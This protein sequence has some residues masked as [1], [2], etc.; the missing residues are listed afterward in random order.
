[1]SPSAHAPS[2][3]RVHIAQGIRADN[4]SHLCAAACTAGAKAAFRILQ[5]MP[6]GA[7]Q[8]LYLDF[9]LGA[10]SISDRFIGFN[11][12]L[13]EAGVRVTLRQLP[14]VGTTSLADQRLV[15]TAME[16]EMEQANCS[17]ATGSSCV[18]DGIMVTARCH[19]ACPLAD[20]PAR[21]VVPAVSSQF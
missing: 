7:T 10:S 16:E 13:E 14:V 19:V 2:G 8:V 12:T 4:T 17:A 21:I 6:S 18:Y 3:T 9:Q 5:Q 15:M 1:M 11:T 20:P